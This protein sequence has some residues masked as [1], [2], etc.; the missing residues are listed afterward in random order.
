MAMWMLWQGHYEAAVAVM[1]AFVCYLRPYELMNLRTADC[2]IGMQGQKGR[3]AE[4]TI[5]VAPFG[6]GESSKTGSYD[7]TVTGSSRTL[8]WITL[9]F[10]SWVR[11]RQDNQCAMLW[12]IHIETLKRLYG[13]AA[14]ALKFPVETCLYQL[15]HG[16]ASHDLASETRRTKK[17]KRA[18][19]G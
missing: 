5:T 12:T 2:V 3:L 9:V 19:G 14:A 18:G 15:R 1:V 8:P 13:M 7:D 16:G 4:S 10:D 17:S 6:R 11:E